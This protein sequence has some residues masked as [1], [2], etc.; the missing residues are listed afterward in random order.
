MVGPAS[1]TKLKWRPNIARTDAGRKTTMENKIGVRGQYILELHN[2]DGSRYEAVLDNM[3]TNVGIN[4]M[5]GNTFKE[6]TAGDD[7]FLG[8]INNSGFTA[9]NAADTLASHAGWSELTAYSGD[10]KAWGQ[11]TVS[12]RELLNGTPVEFTINSSVEI[13][14]VFL[15]NVASG[16]SGTLMSTSTQSTALPAVNGSILKVTYRIYS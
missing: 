1:R 12:N 5:L 3:V 2:P 15:A 11:G 10:R 14:G 13:K 9:L 8:L 6:S 7:W 4:L 16:T